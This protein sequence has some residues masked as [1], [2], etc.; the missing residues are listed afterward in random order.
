MQNRKVKVYT[1][2]AWILGAI[3]LAAVAAWL[4]LFFVAGCNLF[5]IRPIW[6]GF[7][8]ITVA[9]LS[10]AAACV[11]I[12]VIMLARERDRNTPSATL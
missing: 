8:L 1:V 4:V 9:G 3:C 11:F 2:C 6:L 12:Y 10:M 7:L 5:A